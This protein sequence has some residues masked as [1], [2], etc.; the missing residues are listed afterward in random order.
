MESGMMK[1]YALENTAEPGLKPAEKLVEICTAY[2]E[3]KT[4][5]I[6][7][8]YAA[9]SAKQRIDKLV[10]AFNATLPDSAEYA[11]LEDGRQYRIALK[12]N[13]GDSVDLTLERLEDYL[14]VDTGET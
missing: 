11:I 2:F 12:Q 13:I 7:R 8:A 3:E 14:D 10:R 9:M 4:V 5:G 1:I 6:T